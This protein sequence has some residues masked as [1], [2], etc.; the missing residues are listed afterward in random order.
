MP[1]GKGESAWHMNGDMTG[2][3]YIISEIHNTRNDQ[4]YN[5]KF[6]Y[7]HGFHMAVT[8]TIINRFS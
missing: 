5:R 1:S 3:L 8:F 6:L 7:F 2:L 4:L